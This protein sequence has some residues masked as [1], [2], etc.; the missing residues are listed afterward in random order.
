[1][2]GSSGMARKHSSS[3]GRPGGPTPSGPPPASGSGGTPAGGRPHS[4]SGAGS[5][6]K[7][8]PS[9][10]APSAHGTG[11][12]ASRPR[13]GQGFHVDSGR[14][15]TFAGRLGDLQ[16]Q[17][18]SVANGIG[19]ARVGPQSFGTVGQALAGRV[20]QA[21]D[22]MSQHV[23]RIAD[24][25]GVASR[26]TGRVARA[27]DGVEG[28][29]S[30]ALGKLAPGGGAPPTFG[31]GGGASRGLGGKASRGGTGGSR[32]NPYGRPPGSGSGS[33][34]GAGAPS[35]S[36]SPP[37][38]PRPPRPPY[39]LPSGQSG[40]GRP[41][42]GPFAPYQY[43]YGGYPDIPANAH[44]H[45]THGDYNNQGQVTGG[46]VARPDVHTP[47]IDPNR[48]G[49]GVVNAPGNP[50]N[51]QPN[52]VYN[53]PNPQVDFGPWGRYPKHN[54]HHSMYPQGLP[55][56]AVHGMG[57]HAWN[58]GNPNGGYTV[59]PNGGGSW[60]GQAQIPFTPAWNP[61]NRPD[62]PPHGAGSV[63]HGYTGQTVN[64]E[65]YYNP[66]GN[67]ATYYPGNQGRPPMPPPP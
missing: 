12:G 17:L 37:P 19:A 21:V 4:S 42:E 33:G 38:S 27:Y 26:M 8:P 44:Q 34:G 40:H 56:T 65:G 20:T 15:D 54:N 9:P 41:P 35:P 62:L 58:G 59:N 53:H 64:V 50:V 31:G 16:T 5:P 52:G 67:V 43:P 28:K 13:P 1:M 46:H 24:E 60:S 48:Y 25:V 39:E 11:P 47:S 3:S 2:G 30:G 18:S 32:Y 36:P 61:G 10:G 55:D 7:R 63:N 29:H 45:V 22:T 14:I 6:G 57:N 49:Q 23:G 66:N 51:V